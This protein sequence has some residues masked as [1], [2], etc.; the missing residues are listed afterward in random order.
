[1]AL[2][3]Q[4]LRGDAKLDAA[5]VSDAAHIFQGAKGPHVTKIQQALSLADGANIKAD[6]A[7]GPATAAAVR[8]FKTKRQILNFEGKVDEIVGK[9]TIAALDTEMLKKLNGAPGKLGVNGSG[10]AGKLGVNDSGGAG[11]LGVN[12]LGDVLPLLVIVP[13]LKSPMT[14]IETFDNRVPG[15]DKNDLDASNPSNPRLKPAE[16]LVVVALNSSPTF[17]LQAMMGAELRLLAGTIGEEMFLRFV[18]NQRAGAPS[19]F[20]STSDLSAQVAGTDNFKQASKAIADELEVALKKQA[21]T[22]VLDPNALEANTEDK[23][24]FGRRQRVNPN[25]IKTSIDILVP[26]TEIKLQAVIGGSFQGGRVAL[27]DFVANPI[28]MTYTATL[29]FTLIDHFGVDNG[30]VLPPLPHGSPGQIA[31]WILQHERHP[32]HNP[33][34]TTVVIVHNVNG[35]LN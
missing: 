27:V 9:K 12:G 19:V 26:R 24:R 4:L 17:L 6:G 35:K 1:M 8:A 13:F 31:F 22:G 16:A 5:A 34:V 23:G 29:E 25:G 10:G 3:S 32:G 2:Q 21:A 15:P 20:D 28:T 14:L 33:Y 11:K 30:D 18:T 7:F